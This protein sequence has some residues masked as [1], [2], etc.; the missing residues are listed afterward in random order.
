MDTLFAFHKS[1]MVIHTDALTGCQYLSV[2]AGGLIPRWDAQ[3]RQV[4]CRK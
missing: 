4:G 2:S 3:G 1:G